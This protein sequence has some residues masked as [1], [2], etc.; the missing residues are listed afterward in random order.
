MTFDSHKIVKDYV[1]ELARITETREQLRVQ[2]AEAWERSYNTDDD[3]ERWAHVK[4]AKDLEGQVNALTDKGN[5]YM[6]KVD[7]LNGV[8]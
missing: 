1:R 6:F 4:A 7:Q 5:H 2:M 3:D 8:R